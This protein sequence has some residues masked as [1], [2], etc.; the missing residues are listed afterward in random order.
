MRPKLSVLTL[1]LCFFLP[2]ILYAQGTDSI[3]QQDDGMDILVLT[4][5]SV[6][7]S[8]MI[9][10]AIA[11][12]LLAGMITF[13]IITLIFFGILSTAFLIGLAKRSVSAGFKSLL[14]LLFSIGCSLLGLGSILLFNHIVPLSLST[15][16]LSGIG[17]FAGA[18]GGVLLG[19]VT[20]RAISRVLQIAV[21]RLTS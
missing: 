16:S 1:L 20:H 12:A 5:A 4:I 7:I 10:G 18:S 21:A 6:F 3:P 19:L 14:I 15:I 11:G 9:G 8:V 2:V 17:F 13:G